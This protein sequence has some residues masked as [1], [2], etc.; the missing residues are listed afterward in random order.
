MSDSTANDPE[1]KKPTGDLAKIIKLIG[2]GSGADVR[3]ASELLCALS[4]VELPWKWR[5]TVQHKTRLHLTVH[6]QNS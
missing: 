6:M 5:F 3:Q 2:D 4:A 1:I